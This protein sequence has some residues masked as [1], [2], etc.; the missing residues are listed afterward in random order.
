[1]PS[2]PYLRAGR[3]GYRYAGL[4][5]KCFIDAEALARDIARIQLGQV[6]RD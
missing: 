4:S 3:A 5:S 6:P 1:M 2:C